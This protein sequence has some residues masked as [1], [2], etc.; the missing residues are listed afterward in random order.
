MVASVV[1]PE[2]K[3][4]TGKTVAGYSCDPKK[5]DPLDTLMDFVLADKSSY[6]RALFSSPVREDLQTGLR[7]TVDQ[8]WPGYKRNIA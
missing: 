7:Q 6:Q 4:Y 8:H 3:Q 5:R 1:N 2:L